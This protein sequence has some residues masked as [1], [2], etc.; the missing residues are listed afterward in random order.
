MNATDV[1][2]QMGI[3]LG[4]IPKCQHKTFTNGGYT[5]REC[6]RDAEYKVEAQHCDTRL[7]CRYHLR[8]VRRNK[9]AV[10]TKVDAS[11]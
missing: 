10:V 7:L 8:G 4:Y 5:V 1:F 6:Q 3:N 9:T 2:N 11:K